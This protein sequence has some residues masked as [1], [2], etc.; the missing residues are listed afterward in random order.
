MVMPSPL[1]AFEPR[2]NLPSFNTPISATVKVFED[3]E[4]VPLAID[5]QPTSIM[6][7]ALR[8]PN[9][10]ESLE[11]R[12]V[13]RRVR[14]IETD[15]EILLRLGFD[16]DSFEIAI[17]R[18]DNQPVLIAA[19]AIELAP[20][21]VLTVTETDAR[22]ARQS[23]EQLAETWS[24]TL[25][26]ALREAHTARK[27]E[28]QQ[29]RRGL[30]IAMSGL[31]LAIG[32]GLYRLSSLINH[33]EDQLKTA[34]ACPLPGQMEEATLQ[35]SP[36]QRRQVYRLVGNV[37]TILE[38]VVW[39]GGTITVLS[40][41]AATR[42]VA[43][44]LLGFP[45]QLAIVIL[46]VRLINRVGD[47]FLSRSLEVW[48]DQ[49]VLT[50]NAAKRASQRLPTLMAALS[51]LMRLVTAIVGLVVFL[52][53]QPFSLGSVLAGAGIFGAALAV[54]FQTLIKDFTTGLLILWEDQFAVGDVID[55]G[56]TVGSVEAVGLRVTKIRG[57]GGRLSVI[58]NN[59]IAYVHNL[60]KDW[61]RVDFRVRIDG[62][63]DPTEVMERMR[64]V[65][66][67]MQADPEWGD[68]LLDPVMLIGVD[69]LDDRGV[70]ILQWMQ[71]APLAQ[72]DVER[73]YRRRLKLAFEQIGILIAMPQ[74]KLRSTEDEDN[75]ASEA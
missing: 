75:T 27:P 49:Q 22:L 40:Q 7:T 58:P 61:S 33:Y 47:V 16:P 59:Q 25:E 73:E 54:V 63:H 51:G 14:S 60:S 8:T 30:A 71:T 31:T 21:V 39:L 20:R 57:T 2:V 15:I 52:S 42:Q 26:Q 11:L 66:T 44:W 17:D 3:L 72:W 19:D 5:G 67:T 1:Q 53:L 50:E 69:K 23:S 24:A 62:N 13:L 32:L 36:Q 12:P 41:F 9:K 34:P 37:V 74:L 18:I 43:A 38:A 6:L 56:L 68:R 4:Y 46:S 10:T 64:E 70:E 48:A 65:S 35:S 45:L 29:F 28:V 55:V